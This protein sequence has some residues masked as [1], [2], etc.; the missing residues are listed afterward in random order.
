MLER[1]ERGLEG[2]ERIA[3]HTVSAE[4]ALAITAFP[5]DSDDAGAAAEAKAPTE[6]AKDSENAS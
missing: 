3:R 5:D 6:P 1:L 2:Y 4:A